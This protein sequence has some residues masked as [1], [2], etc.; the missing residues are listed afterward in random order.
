MKQKIIDNSILL[1]EKKGFS[2]TSIQDIVDSLDVTKGT[3]Y[4]YFSSKEQL[5]MD[6][7]DDYITDLL[8]RQAK[9]VVNVKTNREKLEATVYLLLTDIEQKGAEGRV[10]FREIRHLDHRH[11]AQIREKRD[12]FRQRIVHILQQGIE[13]GEFRTQL[14]TDMLSFAILGMTN[15]SYQWY[16]PAGEISPKQLTIIFVDLI[17]HGVVPTSEEM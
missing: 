5:L 16:H 6:I 9:A 13:T 10:F 15:W 14:Q 17:L 3:F 2:A 12:T 7:H 11:A 8:A 1:F 4:Y